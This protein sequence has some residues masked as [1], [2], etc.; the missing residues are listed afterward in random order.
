MII[1]H[2][3]STWRSRR[4]IKLG[5]EY[6]VTGSTH[7]KLNVSDSVAYIEQVFGDYLT[8]SGLQLK[9]FSG[10]RIL[11]L[12]PGDN[13]GVALKFIAAGA[14][15]V[16]CVD[17]FYSKR[18]FE[19]QKE[20]YLE[21]IARLNQNEK[22][23]IKGVLYWDHEIHFNPEKIEYLYGKELIEIAQESDLGKFDFVISRSVLQEIDDLDSTFA[24]MDRLLKPGGCMMHKVDM[25]DYGMFSQYGMNP[26]TFLTIPET[27]YKWMVQG[28]GKPNRKLIDYYRRKIKEYAYLT[29]IYVTH[30]TGKNKEIKPHQEKIH[31]EIDYNEEDLSMI[32]KIRPHL[33]NR[34]QPLTN[35]DLLIAGIFIIEQ[36]PMR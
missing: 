1:S 10:K 18:N 31:Y 12:G 16:V 23:N 13:L 25:R 24:V 2:I 11:E 3:V 30:I 22:H 5:Q 33:I 14:K 27:V 29:K 32:R 17:K 35:E 6:S 26:L 19:Q 4:K 9:D 20:I 28:G 8:Y 7:S 34:Y 21:L 15:Q 36:K